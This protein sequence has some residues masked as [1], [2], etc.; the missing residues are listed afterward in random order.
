METHSEYFKDGVH[1]NDEGAQVIAN[2]ISDSLTQYDDLFNYW[3]YVV[4]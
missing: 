3:E 4:S 2:T 1:P